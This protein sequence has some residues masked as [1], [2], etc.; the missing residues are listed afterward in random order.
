MNAGRKIY[1]TMDS[2]TRIPAGYVGIKNYFTCVKAGKKTQIK[3]KQQQ[4]QHQDHNWIIQL[5]LKNVTN[6]FQ[7][8][9]TVAG[10]KGFFVRCNLSSNSP[11]K[12]SKIFPYVWQ[13]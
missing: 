5:A 12:S 3:P 1:L 11:V 9:V 10:V 6:S 13:P 4:H 7:F 8:L 2:S